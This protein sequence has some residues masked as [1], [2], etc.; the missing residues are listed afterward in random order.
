[1]LNKTR[2]AEDQLRDALIAETLG[3]VQKLR[4]EVK[5]LPEILRE[6]PGAVDKEMKRAGAEMISGL[7]GE[8]GRIAQRLAGDAVVAERNRAISMAVL[9]L[10]VSALIFGGTGYTIRMLADKWMI[11][12]AR[13]ELKAANSR[14]DTAIANAEKRASMEIEVLRKN[15]GWVG[16]ENGRLAKKFFDSGAGKV[17]A[18]CDSPVWE[19][20]ETENGKFCVP[21]RR[22][23]F[24][25]GPEQ[26]GWKI[27]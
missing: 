17:A 16:T 15:S 23:I 4:D 24:G 2:S 10:S 14:A 21:L 9:A 7:S 3:D 6:L 26:Y 19:I 13:E 20:V 25:G 1:M 12:A 22:P 18:H 8:V 5:I 27:P 11:V